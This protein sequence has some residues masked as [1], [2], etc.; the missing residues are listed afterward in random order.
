MFIYD[1]DF[2]DQ[3]LYLQSEIDG[4]EYTDD[5]KFKVYWK[6]ITEFLNGNLSL[7]PEGLLDLLIEDMLVELPLIE[8]A[9][10]EE[11]PIISK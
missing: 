8:K 2:V 3:T 6:P 5:R 7:Y 1:A 9:E 4:F 11:Q 10:L